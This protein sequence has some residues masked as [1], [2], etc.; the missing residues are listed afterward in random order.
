MCGD[1][2]ESKF[3]RKF[4]LVDPEH[5]A[6]WEAASPVDKCAAVLSKG[7]RIAAEL[8]AESRQG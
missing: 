8:I 4:D 6:V 1:I 2:Q 7:V 3:G 5:L